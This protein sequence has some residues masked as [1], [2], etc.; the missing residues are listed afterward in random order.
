MGKFEPALLERFGFE[1]FRIP[2]DSG[3]KP[4]NGFN[5]CERRHLTTGKDVIAD[6]H[7]KVHIFVNHPLIQSLIATTNE[8]K[9]LICRELLHQALSQGSARR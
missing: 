4:R 8:K 7:L 9:V 3:N 5:N 2:E 6:A 1:T